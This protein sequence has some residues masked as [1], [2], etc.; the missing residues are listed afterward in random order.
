MSQTITG[1]I[2]WLKNW[3]YD[4]DD[5]DSIIANMPLGITSIELIPYSDNPDGV[6]CYNTPTSVNIDAINLVSDKNILSYYDSESA[7]LS[8]TVLDDED[9]VVVGQIVEFFKGNTSLGTAI[10]NS[11]G[12]ATKSYAST[13][14]GDVSL[15]ATC[16][17]VTATAIT[18]EDCYYY[19]PTEISYTSSS[20]VVETKIC[21]IFDINGQN[22][23]FEFDIKNGSQTGGGWNI[24]ATA[25]YSP[26]S[27]ANYRIY[28]GTDAGKFVI[29]NRTNSSSSNSTGSF[30]SNTYYH[31]KLTKSGTTFAGYYGDNNTSIASKTASWISSYTDWCIYWINWGGTNYIKNIKLKKVV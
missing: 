19:S 29:N 12:V 23:V 13:G 9:N 1:I 5:V 6:I 2:T 16:D 28:I 11:S 27:T 14:S 4:K 3:F 20:T 22:F 17:E 26:P 15:T 30:S 18:I 10:T 25:Q 21:D 24:G 7:T 8:A 31:M